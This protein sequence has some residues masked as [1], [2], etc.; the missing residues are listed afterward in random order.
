MASNFTGYFLASLCMYVYRRAIIW[1]MVLCV[2][3]TIECECWS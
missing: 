2:L 3:W 1:S